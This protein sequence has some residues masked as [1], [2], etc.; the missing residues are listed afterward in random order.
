M[1]TIA[2]P[3][4]T[5]FTRAAEKIKAASPLPDWINNAILPTDMGMDVSG[6]PAGGAIEPAVQA[7]AT[8]LSPLISIYKNKA[9]REAATEEFRA[10][11]QQFLKQNTDIIS[12]VAKARWHNA[13]EAL[14]ERYPRIAAH[15]RQNPVYENFTQDNMNAAASLGMPPGKVYSPMQLNVH[16]AGMANIE[17]DFTAARELLFHE[18][19]HAAQSLG[20]K[21]A[22]EL[23]ELANQITPYKYNPYETSARLSGNRAALDTPRLSPKTALDPQVQLE[24]KLVNTISNPVVANTPTEGQMRALWQEAQRT[25]DWRHVN[26]MVEFG[27]LRGNLAARPPA[28]A[29]RQTAETGFRAAEGTPA[30]Q[31]ATR[32]TK[33]LNNRQKAPMAP[34]QAELDAMNPIDRQL[35]KLKWW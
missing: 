21:N 16:P 12:D 9:A 25:G 3:K 1:P 17:N 24:N 29:L 28:D 18:A 30:R 11:V 22:S 4:P 2:K 23:Y 35:R 15:L 33:I 20:N 5:V 31:A 8:M 14:A 7:G 32:M 27:Q 6:I 19:T 13:A 26:T 10:S 34:T